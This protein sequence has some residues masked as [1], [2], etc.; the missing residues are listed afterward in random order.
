LGDGRLGPQLKKEFG[1]I[2]IANE[3]FTQETAEQVV[4]CGEA[5]AVAFGKLF[6]ANPDLP[7]RFREHLALNEPIAETFFAPGAKGYTDYP[8]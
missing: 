1:G 5:D 8:L 3:G 4:S 2:Y 6:I 7:K